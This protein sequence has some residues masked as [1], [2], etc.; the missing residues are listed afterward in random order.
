MA[1]SKNEK[2][3]MWINNGKVDKMIDST[4]ESLYVGKTI[5]GNKWVKGTLAETVK[6]RASI[7]K[8]M[9]INDPSVYDMFVNKE[10]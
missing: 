6:N 3:K 1:K 5:N 2:H 9:Q 4:S 7:A 8:Q 10:I